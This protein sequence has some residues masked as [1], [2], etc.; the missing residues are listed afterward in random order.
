MS[1]GEMPATCGAK[2][3]RGEPC[4]KY[5]MKGK[6]RCRNHGGA[7]TG[8]KTAKGKARA[9]EAVTTHGAH[10]TLGVY[11]RLLA[12]A[13]PEIWNEIPNDTS[14]ERELRFARLRLANLPAN[15]GEAARSA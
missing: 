11:E 12:A 4:R 6:T 8:A 14:L 9:V 5:P 3:R 10:A 2:N 13:R 7:S 1:E 15:A